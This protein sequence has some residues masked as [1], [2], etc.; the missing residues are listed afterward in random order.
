MK[1]VTL[2]L[3][4]KK[5]KAPIKVDGYVFRGTNEGMNFLRNRCFVR[6]NADIGLNLGDTLDLYSTGQETA[7]CEVI[8]YC[9]IFGVHLNVFH[10]NKK[11]K[12]YE[13]QE[14]F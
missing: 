4:D 6:L 10:W 11:L 12:E 5:S 3:W 2:E 9:S 1:K 7:L 14:I 8:R 13:L